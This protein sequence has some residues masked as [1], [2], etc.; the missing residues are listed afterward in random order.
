MDPGTYKNQWSATGNG[1]YWA[2]AKLLAQLAHEKKVAKVTG[3]RK[4]AEGEAGMATTAKR[5][6]AAGEDSPPRKRTS[7]ELKRDAEELIRRINA[8]DAGIYAV[9][10]S[11]PQVVAGIKSFLQRDGIIKAS[12]LSALGD[13]NSNSLNTFLSGKKQ[14]QCGNVAYR[15]AYVFLEKLRILEGKRK[16][17]ARLRNEVENP[18]GVRCCMYFSFLLSLGRVHNDSH[19]HC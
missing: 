17:V 15:T 18:N 14:D 5:A 11:C 6:K 8:V 7:A 12:L 19:L 9:Y 3:K 4:T 13:I 16:S 1:T 10:D 2:A